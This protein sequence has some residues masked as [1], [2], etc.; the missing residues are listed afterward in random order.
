[1]KRLLSALGRT[2]QLTQRPVSL[3]EAV[4]GLALI[5]MGLQIVGRYVVTAQEQLGRTT[6]Q[7]WSVRAALKQAEADLAQLAE[8]AEDLGLDVDEILTGP[9][10]A[11]YPAREDTDPLATGDPS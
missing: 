4:A 11:V 6:L 9:A 8:S 3:V 10:D 2:R 5:G 1:M 7:A